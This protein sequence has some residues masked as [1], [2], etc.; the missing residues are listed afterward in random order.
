MLI[1]GLGQCS[2]DY[3][4]VVDT[5]PGVDKKEEV[6]E[7]Q[8]QGGGPVATALAALA[9]LGVRCRF[10]GMTGDDSAGEKIRQSLAEEGIDISGLKVREGAISQK[11]FVAIEKD[12]AKRTIFWKRPS[13]D[14]LKTDEIEKDFLKGSDFLLL[15]GLMKDAS[16]YAAQRAKAL[17]IPVMLDA[18]RLRPGM[19]DL[20]RMADYVVASEEFAKDLGWRISP[21]ALA[22]EREKMGAEVLTVT[23]GE[24]GSISVARD[25]IIEAPAFEVN[26]VDTTGAGDVFHGGYIYGILRGWELGDTIKFASA[27]AALKCMKIGGRAGIPKLNEIMKFLDERGHRG[28]S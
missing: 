12:T 25:G 19:T 5:Y 24:R 20:A 8:E 6:I 10:Y 15:D 26:A 28:F 11:A 16:L 4:A 3:I 23:L 14:A 2:L 27:M 9:R 21:S 13:G 1:T 7:W 22:G 18:G 17:N